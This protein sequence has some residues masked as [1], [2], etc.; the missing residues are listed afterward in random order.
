MIGRLLATV[1]DGEQVEVWS[2]EIHN[3]KLIINSDGDGYTQLA[4]GE[5]P[6]GTL[7]EIE[8]KLRSLPERYDGSYLRGEFE[9]E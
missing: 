1:G 4:L 9:D 5:G 7:R 6:W 3:G 8:D 2:G